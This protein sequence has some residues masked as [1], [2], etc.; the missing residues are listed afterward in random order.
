M[1]PPAREGLVERERRK[2]VEGVLRRAAVTDR[3]SMVQV[4]LNK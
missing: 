4:V 1:G 2:R 3:D